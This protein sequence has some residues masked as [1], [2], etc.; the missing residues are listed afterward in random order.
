[1]VKEIITDVE[2]LSGRCD[3]VNVRDN[4]AE[5]RQ[6][7]LDLKDTIRAN[8]GCLGLAANQI[9]ASMRMFC[10][11]FNGDIRTFINPVITEAKSITLNR[12]GCM[13]LP[14]RQFIRPR[15]SEISVIYQTPLG[16]TESR[17][18]LGLAACVFQHELDHL[19]GITLE[20]LGLEIDEKFDEAT[21]EERD[22]LVKNYL[23]S[24]DL[25]QKEINKEIEEDPELKQIND[26]S[27]FMQKVVS[28][29][30][31]IER[32]ATDEETSKKITEKIKKNS[33]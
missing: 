15:N 31:Q 21:E 11:N 16:K 23:D 29:E 18:F 4:N 33:K 6:L 30:V 19:D 22:E 1:M 7:T 8:E 2:K 32:E 5:V 13:S 3:E 26:A 20:D 17:K 24:L 25:K 28:G 9:G 14:G 12:E 27:K 10:I